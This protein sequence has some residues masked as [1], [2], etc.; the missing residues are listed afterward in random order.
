MRGRRLQVFFAKDGVGQSAEEYQVN[1][2]GCQKR[3]VVRACSVGLQQI[4]RKVGHEGFQQANRRKDFEV[5]DDQ[6]LCI[7][8]TKLSKRKIPMAAKAVLLATANRN[9]NRLK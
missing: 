1:G 7:V 3:R 5:A 8:G 9:R 2:D 4:R 6:Q